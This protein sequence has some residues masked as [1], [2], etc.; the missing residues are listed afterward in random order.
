MLLN[1]KEIWYFTKCL[2]L[3]LQCAIKCQKRDCTNAL[4]ICEL[5]P[6]CNYVIERKKGAFA[7]L[8]R[9]ATT[10]ERARCVAFVTLSFPI[11]L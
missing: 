8:K 10:D 4:K 5:H 2:I 11:I 6:K 1:I 7:V 3:F 9:A